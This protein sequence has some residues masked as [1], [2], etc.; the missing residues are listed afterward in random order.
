VA[1]T[2]VR[3]DTEYFDELLSFWRQL[4]RQMFANGL[5][6]DISACSTRE[7]RS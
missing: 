3:K 1:Q 4:L 2:I 6:I 5:G 7:E